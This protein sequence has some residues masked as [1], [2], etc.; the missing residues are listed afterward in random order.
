MRIL[1]LGKGAR[2]D[3]LAWSLSGSPLTDRI[4]AAPGNPGIARFADIVELDIY[5]AAAVTDFSVAERID[6]VVIGP[7]D[8]LVAGI[9]DHLRAKGIPVFGPGSKGARLEGSKSFAKDFM[10]RHRV[11]TADYVVCSNMECARKAIAGRKPP[12]IVKADGLAA[13]KGSFVLNTEDEALQISRKLLE[14]GLLGDS[15]RKIVIEDCLEG[16]EMTVLALTDGNVIKPLSPSQDHKRAYDN[17]EGPNTGGMGAYS[18]VPWS[19]PSLMKKIYESV[20]LPT[21]EGIKAENIDFCGIL[22][23]G[24]MIN[25]NREPFVIEYN[26]RFGDPEAQV[27]LP[28]L[29][30][31]LAE[32][33]LACTEKRLADVSVPPPVKW[34]AGVVLASGG[35]PGEYSKGIEVEGLDTNEYVEDTLIFHAG[36]LQDSNGKII[37]SGGRVL[38]VVGISKDSLEEAV[39]KAYRRIDGIHFKDMH[40][41]K[42]IAGKARIFLKQGDEL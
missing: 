2:E 27:V 22:Y 42:D 1:L 34:A 40:Y 31:D 38:T 4:Y 13:G 25:S 33:M 28:V 30:G 5:D 20:L 3:A 24:L 16:S 12:Y 11:P 23:A 18:P 35:Y 32:I 41:R 10:K 15:G 36:T 26:V 19:D 14:E 21:L 29:E 6:L 39:K 9:P 17:D 7:E 8:I 37:T